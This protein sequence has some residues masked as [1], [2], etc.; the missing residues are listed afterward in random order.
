M[1]D[2]T[3]RPS[4]S[5]VNRSET[6]DTSSEHSNPGTELNLPQPD[7]T[8]D[9]IEFTVNPSSNSL[10]I[11]AAETEDVVTAL[12]DQPI[13]SGSPRNPAGNGAEK[14]Q[15]GETVLWHKGTTPI[16]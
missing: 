11:P 16:V 8:S 7:S 1:S 6:E 10:I 13:Q 9:F 14:M 15:C 12:P 2:Y 5:H 3:A 4:S